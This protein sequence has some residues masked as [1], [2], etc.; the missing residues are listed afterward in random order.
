MPGVERPGLDKHYGIHR[1][2]LSHCLRDS[3][4]TELG[5]RSFRFTDRSQPIS[6]EFKPSRLFALCEY[7][8][9]GPIAAWLSLSPIPD[10]QEAPYF[11]F[12]SQPVRRKLWNHYAQ[13]SYSAT[14]LRIVREVQYSAVN[15]YLYPGRNWHQALLLAKLYLEPSHVKPVAFV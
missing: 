13:N 1:H 4:T 6:D 11:A 5:S 14:Y 3:S 15:T 9:P 8:F 10:S 12:A 7:T 2:H